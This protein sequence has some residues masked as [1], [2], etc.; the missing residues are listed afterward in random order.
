MRKNQQVKNFLQQIIVLD[1]YIVQFQILEQLGDLL[2]DTK[3]LNS[4]QKSLI[5][6]A[7]GVSIKIL[8]H[9]LII[10]SSAFLALYA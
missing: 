10:I 1:V 6:E 7:L 5:G 9:G 8:L 4:K 3:E 2:I